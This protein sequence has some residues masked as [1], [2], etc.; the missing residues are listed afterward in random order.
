[1][2]VFDRISKIV[3]HDDVL[4][5]LVSFARIQYPDWRKKFL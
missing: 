5:E 1:S 3:N 2:D 4:K